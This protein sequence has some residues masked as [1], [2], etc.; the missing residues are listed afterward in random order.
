MEQIELCLLELEDVIFYG[1]VYTNDPVATRIQRLAFQIPIRH[2][3]RVIDWLLRNR[4]HTVAL[5]Q[6][7]VHHMIPCFHTIERQGDLVDLLLGK[8]D[9]HIIESE[10]IFTQEV[11]D[12]VYELMVADTDPDD[13]SEEELDY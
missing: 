3:F 10:N 9:E 7:M 6:Q 2:R 5:F 1:Q 8:N 13:L 4:E 11:S 12:I